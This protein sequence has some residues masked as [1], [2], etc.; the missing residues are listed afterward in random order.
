MKTF[1]EFTTD[2]P[3][4]ETFNTVYPWHLVRDTLTLSMYE[5]TVPLKTGT[6]QVT[7]EIWADTGNREAPDHAV[8]VIFT[9]GRRI[10]TTGLGDDVKFGIF[11]TVVDTIKDYI[12]KYHPHTIL[13]SAEKSKTGSD[14]RERLYTS[15]IRRFADAA[16]YQFLQKTNYK[17]D[18][19]VFS[20]RRK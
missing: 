11:A 9:V 6:Q 18:M 5:F 8:S 16:G 20:L 13:F 10:D 2:T 14:A 17:Q 7:V 1:T 3:L 12:K 15:L 4:T 19:V